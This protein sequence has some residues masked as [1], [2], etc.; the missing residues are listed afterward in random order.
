MKSYRHIFNLGVVAVLFAM[1][2]MALGY[3]RQARLM[4]LLIGIPVLIIALIHTVIDFRREAHEKEK[5]RPTEE[6]LIEARRRFAKE[7]N[8][9]LWV[10]GLF[11]S[12]YLLGFLISTLLFTFLTLKVRSRYSWRSSLGVAAG[13]WAFVYFLMV[14]LLQADLHNGLIVITLRKSLLGY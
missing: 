3:N 7:I 12:V 4:P 11:V 6:R 14:K 2:I 13:C 8:V 9:S 5:S 1:V 10:I